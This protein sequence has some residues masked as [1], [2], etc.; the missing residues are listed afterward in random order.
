MVVLWDITP[1]FLD[2]IAAHDVYTRTA[3]F[4]RTASR[5]K[6][7]DSPCGLSKC[8]HGSFTKSLTLCDD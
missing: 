5:S 4:S 7:S 6:S 3:V 2:N 8:T 1:Q